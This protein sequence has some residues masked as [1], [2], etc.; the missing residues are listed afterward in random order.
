MI[1]IRQV[2]SAGDLAVARRLFEEYWRAFD[3]SPSFQNFAEEVAGLP[4]KYA[5]PGGRLAIAWVDG[6]PAGC[7]ALRPFDARRA[8]AKR[9]YVRPAFRG[10][11]L[12]HAL[13]RWVIEEARAAG[14]DELVGDTMPQMTAA[15]EMYDRVGFERV[16]PYDSNPTPGAVY[17]RLRLHRLEKTPPPDHG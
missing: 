1:E 7:V 11:G 13:L 15:L 16:G 4:G 6:E 8:E 3:F 12:G 10:R 9:L 2:A 5:P 14:L 17:L